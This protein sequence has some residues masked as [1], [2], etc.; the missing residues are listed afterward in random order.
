[1]KRMEEKKNLQKINLKNELIYPLLF[2]YNHYLVDRLTNM[3]SL[4]S[5]LSVTVNLHKFIIALF[6]FVSF[7]L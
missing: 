2:F 3:F 4:S 7:L 6:V 1:M 5:T